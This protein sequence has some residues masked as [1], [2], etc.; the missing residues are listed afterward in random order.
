MFS[1]D[2]E[3]IMH[4]GPDYFSKN[5]KNTID[6]IGEGKLVG[7]R[8]DLSPTDIDQLNSLYVSNILSYCCTIRTIFQYF[9]FF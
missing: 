8:D 3:S 4:Y 2:L 7:Q 6:V 5:G 9:F 1:Y